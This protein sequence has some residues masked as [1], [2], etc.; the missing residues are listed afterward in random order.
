[1]N[2]EPN[3]QHSISAGGPAR[4]V[5]AAR[6]LFR[7]FGFTKTAMQEIAAACDMSAANL[8]RFY[9]NKLAIGVA[10]T[11][12]EQVLLLS[13]CD[14]AVR[15]AGSGLEARLTALFDTIIDATR[16]TIKRAPLLLELR[17][18]VARENQEL[19]REF[20]REIENR[21]V[22]ILA[23][24][25]RTNSATAPL[26]RQQ[27]RMILMAS[28]PFVLPWMLLN[29]PFGDPRPMVAPLIHSLIFSL[30]DG[31]SAARPMV[32]PVSSGH[33]PLIRAKRRARQ[34]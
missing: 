16:R 11:A 22:A 25:R 33:S 21:I 2:N 19:R 13:A 10:V 20:L 26:L 7:Q 14:E 4:I 34:A 3:I 1:M 28:A 9:E 32:A 8:Y 29:E 27:G 23:D 15:L 18:T 24:E 6:E 30:S 12:A 5:A 17:L 31:T